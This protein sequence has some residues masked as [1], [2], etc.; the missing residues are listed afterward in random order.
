MKYC[1]NCGFKLILSHASFTA[2]ALGFEQ[3]QY[4][5]REDVGSLSGVSVI[6]ENGVITEQNLTVL[7][8]SVNG[9][10]LEGEIYTCTK[11]VL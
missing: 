10:A 5:V 1:H 8:Q 9:L 3:T 2:I 4:M 7:L 11:V 6:K